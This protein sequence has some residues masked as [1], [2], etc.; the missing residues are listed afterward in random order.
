M[1]ALTLVILGIE[2]VLQLAN[3]GFIGGPRGVGWRLTAVQDYGFSAAVLDRVLVH[4]DYSFNMLRRFVT[5]AFI[6]AELTQV[7]FCASLTLAL[8]KFT[9]TYYGGVKVLAIYLFSCIVGAIVFGLF[10]ADTYPLYGGFPPVY[11][12]IGAYTYAIWLSLGESG[13][14][15][16]LAF[17]LIG[18]LL[19]I[20]LAF[21]LIFGSSLVWIAELSGFLAGFGISLLLA[22]GGWNALVDRV[23]QRS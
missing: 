1:I 5:Y 12:L 3:Q 4:G 13:E 6:N 22:P 16:L 2:A 8:G 9:A 11:G 23:R 19:G 20:Q 14:N 18:V 10:A 15:Q 21:G 7:A 17:R